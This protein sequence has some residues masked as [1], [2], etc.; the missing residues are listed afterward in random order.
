MGI[1]VS[2]GEERVELCPP[3]AVRR[4]RLRGSPMGGGWSFSLNLKGSGAKGLEPG[5]L[6]VHLMRPT[7]KTGAGIVEGP[8]LTATLKLIFRA[9]PVRGGSGAGLTFPGRRRL[10]LRSF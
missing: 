5:G 10:S 9:F 1:S 8:L 6:R 2:L 4:S 3:L 7:E